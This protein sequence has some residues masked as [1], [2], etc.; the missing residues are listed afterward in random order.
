MNASSTQA[1]GGAEERDDGPAAAAAAAA[2]G[3]RPRTLAVL[4]L[5]TITAL[6]FS[7]LGAYA[8]TDALAA[9]DVLPRRPAGPD[10]RPWWLLWGFGAIM[11]A[12]AAAAAVARAVS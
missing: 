1:A 4:A 8:V 3:R 9:A 5:M 2:A 11:T 7:Y 12:F 6:L 10:P